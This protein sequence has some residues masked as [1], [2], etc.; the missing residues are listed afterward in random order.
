MDSVGFALRGIGNLSVVAGAA[1]LMAPVACSS[2]STG[3]NRT[4]QIAA[5]GSEPVAGGGTLTFQPKETCIAKDGTTAVMALGAPALA[6]AF[7]S[8]AVDAA[9][10]YVA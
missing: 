1:L 10:L 9:H 8:P 4:A 5:D 3:A 2:P 6:V 7:G